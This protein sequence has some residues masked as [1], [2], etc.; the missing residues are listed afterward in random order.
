M[1]DWRN[2]TQ[3]T[4][5]PHPAAVFS[6]AYSP[7]GTMLAA[8]GDGGA[9]RLWNVEAPDK[10][11]VLQHPPGAVTSVAFAPDGQTVVTALSG[12]AQPR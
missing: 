3:R 10:P 6:V 9:A 4:G 5:Y 11:S 7:D 12:A 2:G 1:W 8:S